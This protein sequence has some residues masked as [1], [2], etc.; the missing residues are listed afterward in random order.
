VDRIPVHRQDLAAG[1]Q[2]DQ[3]APDA[4]AQVGDPGRSRQAPRPVPGDRLRRRLLVAVP[5]EQHLGGPGELGP[6]LDPQLM[7]GHRGRDEA[8][9][10]VTAQRGRLGQARHVTGMPG[11]DPGQ[12]LLAGIGQQHGR[13]L[14]RHATMLR[15]AARPGGLARAR[16]A[17]LRQAR[18]PL[19][20]RH[21]AAGR[22]SRSTVNTL[23]RSLT[24]RH[25]KPRKL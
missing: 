23:F 9:R 17:G 4:A 16:R 3:V 22:T 25:G 12:Q 6:G 7:L 14:V 15:A 13:V 19:A 2:G 20:G 18:A 1:R 10:V 11:R 21:G 24:A 8:G 5:G